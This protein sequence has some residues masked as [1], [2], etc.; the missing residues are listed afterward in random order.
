M[1]GSLAAA[2]AAPALAQPA[3]AAIAIPWQVARQAFAYVT[4]SAPHT[5]A[6]VIGMASQLQAAGQRKDASRVGPDWRE[7]GQRPTLARRAAASDSS[8]PLTA[9]ARMH[10][11]REHDGHADGAERAGERRAASPGLGAHI[12]GG[13]CNGVQLGVVGGRSVRF[14]GGQPCPGRGWRTALRTCAALCLSRHALVLIRHYVHEGWEDNV[15][16][17]QGDPFSSPS[18]AAVRVRTWPKCGQI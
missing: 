17:P 10:I 5:G 8:P 12:V 4:P 15:Q 7:G 2:V 18:A 3:W 16:L 9:A 1:L 13:S 14:E 6:G 11:C